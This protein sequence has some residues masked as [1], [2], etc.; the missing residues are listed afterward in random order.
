MVR[1]RGGE[2]IASEELDL[3]RLETLFA[4]LAAPALV[5]FDL[6]ALDQAFAPGVSAPAARGLAPGPWLRAA[7]LAGRSPAVA[8]ADVCELC[9]PA[10]DGGRTARLAALTAWEVLRGLA[11]RG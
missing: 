4:E 10:D 7:F 9:P 1:A 2:G 3:P 5:T 8:S 11:Q 6:D